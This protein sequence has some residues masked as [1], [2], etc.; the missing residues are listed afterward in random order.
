DDAHDEMLESAFDEFRSVDARFSTYKDASDISRLN[1][2]E[3]AMHDTHAEVQD[4]LSR[5]ARLRAATRGYFDV[6]AASHS[7]IDP[8]GLVKGWSVDR[9]AGMLA[10]LGARNFAINAGGDVIVRG[11]AYPD[12]CWRVGIQHPTLSDK[13]AAVVVANDLAIAT[14]GAYARGAHIINPHTRRA[15]S[16]VL[17]VTITGPDLATAD[18]YATAAFAMGTQGPAWTARLTGYE[19]MTILSD[20]RVLSTPGFPT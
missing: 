4:V 19:A 10:G 16:G 20:D 17:S 11:C 7:L 3:I 13:V 14:S 1:R 18:A 2:G 9:V 15:P 6:C 5:C 8:S 12:D